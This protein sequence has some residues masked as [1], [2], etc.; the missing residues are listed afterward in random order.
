MLSSNLFS[1][2]HIQ[3]YSFTLIHSFTTFKVFFFHCFNQRAKDFLMLK[4]S[5]LFSVLLSDF[6]VANIFEMLLFLGFFDNILP[7]FSSYLPEQ[8]LLSL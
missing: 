5:G 2:L 6:D 4:C 3:V 1:P 8:F 7:R